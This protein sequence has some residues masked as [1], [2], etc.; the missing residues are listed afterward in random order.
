MWPVAPGCSHGHSPLLWPLGVLHSTWHGP[1]FHCR[2]WH[3][4]AEK[5]IRKEQI[6]LPKTDILY[7]FSSGFHQGCLCQPG[8]PPCRIRARGSPCPCVAAEEWNIPQN[9]HFSFSSLCFTWFLAA[10]ARLLVLF[11]FPCSYQQGRV[12]ARSCAP[13]I[14]FFQQSASRAGGDTLPASVLTTVWSK[15]WVPKEG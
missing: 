3:W 8:H 14:S 5:K 4:R 9:L 15:G 13:R 12:A 10:T 6:R 1:C 11:R 2:P 7:C